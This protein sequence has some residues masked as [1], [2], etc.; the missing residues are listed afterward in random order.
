MQLMNF[1]TQFR[2]QKKTDILQLPS[3]RDFLIQ[4]KDSSVNIGISTNP[5][6]KQ[7]KGRTPRIS[8]R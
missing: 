4:F 2:R 6:I 5:G 1:P 8:F 7:Q 3:A